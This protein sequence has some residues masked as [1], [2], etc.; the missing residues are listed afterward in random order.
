MP[1]FLGIAC[2]LE[3]ETSVS[4]LTQYKLF[5][6]DDKKYTLFVT[7][8]AHRTHVRKMHIQ[9]VSSMQSRDEKE[10]KYQNCSVNRPSC[11]NETKN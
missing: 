5:I 9:L 8:T 10:I 7:V 3:A 4:N 11:C 2:T 1:K 6:G